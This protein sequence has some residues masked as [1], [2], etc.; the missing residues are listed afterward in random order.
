MIREPTVLV[1]GAGASAPFGYPCGSHL[2]ELVCGAIEARNV[3]GPFFDYMAQ[4]AFAHEQ[5]DAFGYALRYSGTT[6]VDAFLETR[7]EFL[8]VGKAAMA[9]FLA[10]RESQK[11]LFEKS[12][13]DVDGNWYLYL[14]A[15]LDTKFA[16]FRHNALTVV[17][18]NYDRSLEHFLCCALKH[19]FNKPEDACAEQLKGVPIY[20]LHGRL[21]LLPW[22]E[23]DQPK[24]SYGITDHSQ[25]FESSKAIH[26]ISEQTPSGLEFDGAW[27]ALARA[28]RIYLLGF[29]YHQDNIARL[30]LDRARNE[31]HIA[32]TTV[33]CSQS[34][35]KINRQEIK[36]ALGNRRTPGPD[37]S[38][39]YDP[40]NGCYGVLRTERAALY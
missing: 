39:P 29:G 38:I 10:G 30:H 9:F 27:A 37:V 7:T 19:R 28:K 2:H 33:G 18:F 4:A 13:G 15:A 23:G 31:A 24:R 3:P 14:C 11:A 40:G 34:E 22:E 12:N 6:S 36:A 25:V 1:L 35:A 26:I 8:E 21:G 32:G 16:D 20:H 5:V 17:T